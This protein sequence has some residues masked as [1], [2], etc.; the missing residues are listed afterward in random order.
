MALV[1]YEN[2]Q[3]TR[4]EKDYYIRYAQ[5]R[6][7][8][9]EI[10]ERITNSLTNIYSSTEENKILATIFGETA[11]QLDESNTGIELL[12]HIGELYRIFRDSALPKSREE[13][14]S[15]AVLYNVLTDFEQFLEL[16][17]EFYVEYRDEQVETN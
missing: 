3:F 8:Q 2:K 12:N 11:E 14:E 17:R 16:K 4:S 15:R 6:K 10:L 9:Y 7:Q 13:F 1:E 5:M